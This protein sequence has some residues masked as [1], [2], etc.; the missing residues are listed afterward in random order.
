MSKN[1]STKA[2]E[3]KT[4]KL[5]RAAQETGVLKMAAQR[6]KAL[7]SAA[8]QDLARG[9]ARTIEDVYVVELATMS[10]AEKWAMLKLTSAVMLP[11]PA[12][13]IKD[14]ET[15][16]WRDLTVDP[17]GVGTEVNAQVRIDD[18]KRDRIVCFIQPAG[19]ANLGFAK[20]IVDKKVKTARIYKTAP[21][22]L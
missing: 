5:E 1:S 15:S 18:E 17:P 8:V 14:P 6:K 11:K 21:V 9:V 22:Q 7:T 16:V 4:A 19:K 2:A 13:G 10:R 20:V 12:K 3:A